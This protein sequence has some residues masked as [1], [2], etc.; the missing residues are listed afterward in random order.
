M[1]VETISAIT[2]AVRDMARSVV[3]YRDHVGLKTALRG[4]GGFIHQLPRG[5]Q[6]TST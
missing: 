4:R 3:F 2:L 6:L 1:G 5:R